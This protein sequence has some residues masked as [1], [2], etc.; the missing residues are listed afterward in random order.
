MLVG[1]TDREGVTL[2]WP[3]KIQTGSDY[4]GTGA[5]LEYWLPQNHE[6]LVR[7]CI[8]HFRFPEVTL[9]CVHIYSAN[10]IFI[11]CLLH[12][13]PRSRPRLRELLVMQRGHTCH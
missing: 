11:E 5:T 2:C 3:G 8:G 13:R 7:I 12:A 4:P 6:I 1:C 9:P 10:Q